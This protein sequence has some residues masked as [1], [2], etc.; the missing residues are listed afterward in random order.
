VTLGG[1]SVTYNG[2]PAALA[3]V[4]AAQ[5]NVLVPDSVTPGKV[6]VLV[7]RNGLSSNPYLITATPAQPAVY[8]PPDATGTA[9][10]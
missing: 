8:A 9:F 1:N 2:A 3:Y 5:I 6:Q 4:S 10:S 7:D